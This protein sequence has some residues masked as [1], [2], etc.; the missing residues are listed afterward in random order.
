MSHVDAMCILH[1]RNI[2]YNKQITVPVFWC[3]ALLLDELFAFIFRVTE[4]SSPAVSVVRCNIRYGL[5][6]SVCV[7]SLFLN[8][9]VF[10]K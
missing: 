4:D 10:S 8:I 6:V 5:L 1:C 2:F 9:I 7:M 3:D